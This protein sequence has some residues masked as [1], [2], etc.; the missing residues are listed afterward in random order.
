MR[1]T[2]NGG[3]IIQKPTTK[4]DPRLSPPLGVVDVVQSERD[5]TN[6]Y[7]SLEELEGDEESEEF[8]F[9]DQDVDPG[10][11]MVLNTPGKITLLGQSV[12]QTKDGGTVVD[13]IIDVEEVDGATN[14]EVRTTKA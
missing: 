14:Y 12:R 10:Q 1:K 6:V 3:N 11:S 8:L 5:E 9:L 7:D 2:L 13:V 4:I